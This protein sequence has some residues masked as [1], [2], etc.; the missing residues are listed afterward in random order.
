MKK[1]D[2]SSLFVLNKST[3]RAAIRL[4]GLQFLAAVGW[5]IN[6]CRTKKPGLNSVAKGSNTRQKKPVVSQTRDLQ[7]KEKKK[8]K[9]EPPF[10]EKEETNIRKSDLTSKRCPPL[11]NQIELAALT[12][13]PHNLLTKIRFYGSWKSAMVVLDL[14]TYQYPK[15]GE[16][17]AEIYLVS[18]NGRLIAAKNVGELDVDYQLGTLFYQIFDHIHLPLKKKCSIVGRLGERLVLLSDA[19]EVNFRAS[20]DKLENIPIV[21]ISGRSFMAEKELIVPQVL[22]NLEDKDLVVT[23]KKEWVFANSETQFYDSNELE[24]YIVCDLMGKVLS[25]YGERFRDFYTYPAIVC[26][27]KVKSQGHS[28]YAQTLVRLSS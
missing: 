8:V 19:V 28:Y 18:E 1:F 17:L 13:R 16:G 5:L 26:L 24:G 7:V 27:R 12:K 25:R 6:G 23:E 14:P 9:E 22:I 21:P 4:F 10:V 20:F 11:N 15:R 3:R 2:L